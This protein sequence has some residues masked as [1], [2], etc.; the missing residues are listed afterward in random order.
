[1]Y[2]LPLDCVDVPL[3]LLNTACLH[4]FENPDIADI[5]VE[6]TNFAFH[7]SFL[8]WCVKIPRPVRDRTIRRTNNC[9]QRVFGFTSL[10]NMLM[11][12]RIDSHD[13]VWLSKYHADSLR[14]LLMNTQCT[15]E[16]FETLLHEL[17]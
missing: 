4:I 6:A 8:N 1:M 16:S 9:W 10:R 15:H 7:W 5:S 3:G 14:Q 11:V 12:D 17:Q 13:T 2:E